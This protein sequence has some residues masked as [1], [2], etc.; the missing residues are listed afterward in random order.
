VYGDQISN[1]TAFPVS[2]NAQKADFLRL[3]N[4]MFGYSVPEKYC[5]IV[6]LA[7]CSVFIQGTNLWLLTAYKG[8]DPESSSNGNSNLTPGVDKNAVGL[9]RTFAF[10]INVKM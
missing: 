1:G 9:G 10:G 7:S 6:K 4:L 2:E 5:R 8:T 3:N